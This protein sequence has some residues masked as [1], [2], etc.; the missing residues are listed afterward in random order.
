LENRRAGTSK[1]LR[2]EFVDG[3]TLGFESKSK[4]IGL[5]GLQIPV[6]NTDLGQMTLFDAQGLQKAKF[7][8]QTIP[9]K[10]VVRY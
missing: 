7:T 3:Q 2:T 10:I 5:G 4:V 8:M 9:E 6:S 1:L